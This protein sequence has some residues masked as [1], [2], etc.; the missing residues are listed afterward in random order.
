MP[1][2]Q[3]IDLEKVL[4]SLST[5]CPKCRHQIQP[6]EIRRISSTEMLCPKCKVLF[7]PQ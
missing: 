4:A 5:S 2:K 6:S 3:K 7:A 1:R